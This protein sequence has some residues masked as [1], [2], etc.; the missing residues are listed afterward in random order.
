MDAKDVCQLPTRYILIH[1]YIQEDY[2]LIFED[3]QATSARTFLKENF[4]AQN[5]SETFRQ[6][7]FITFSLNFVFNRK[8]SN[9]DLLM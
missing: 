2:D 6:W 9:S 1:H 7:Q 4:N 3:F 5:Y 8:I